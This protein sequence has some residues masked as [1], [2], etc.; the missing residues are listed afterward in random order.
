MGRERAVLASLVA[1]LLVLWAGFLLHRAP[2][3][4]GSLAGGVLAVTGATLMVVISL[5]YMAVKRIE[6]LRQR[7]SARFSMGK[8]LT[9][10][11]HASAIGAILALLHTGHRFESDLGIALTTMMMI[12]VLSGYAGRHLLGRVA[13]DLREKRSQLAKL[14]TAYN[15]AVGASARNPEA[16]GISV[17]SA[18]TFS[19]QHLR[20]ALA[21]VM[22]PAAADSIAH[23]AARLAESIAELEYSIRTHGRY[24]SLL[25]A[26]LKVHIAASLAFYVL[27]AMHVWAS[28]HFGLR[29]FA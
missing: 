11:V 25:A 6:P 10:H 14:E 20:D 26:W 16:A 22:R 21:G 3:F 27:L 15:E 18:S 2:R 24:Q 4:P 1:V 5:A 29:W 23:R 13:L 7:F 19:L 17:A 12:A 9:W 8:L 28:I